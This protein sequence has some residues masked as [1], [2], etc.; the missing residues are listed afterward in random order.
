MLASK[1]NKKSTERSWTI[2][3]IKEEKERITTSK[4]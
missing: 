2:K 1:N 4:K 3:V